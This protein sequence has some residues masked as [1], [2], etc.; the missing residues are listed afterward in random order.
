MSNFPALI[1]IVNAGAGGV[2]ASGHALYARNSSGFKVN[3]ADANVVA[4]SKFIGFSLNSGAENQPVDV[5]IAGIAKGCLADGAF[6][7]ANIGANVYLSGT[8]G[9]ITATAPST[10]GDTV[11]KCGILLDGSGTAWDVLIQPQ[12]IA[13]LN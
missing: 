1:R 7:A 9:T 4:T 10:T 6:N 3:S 5:Q 2:A 11:F 8:A 13:Q 12:F